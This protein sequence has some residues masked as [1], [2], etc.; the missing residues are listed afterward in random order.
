MHQPTL[1]IRKQIID[2]ICGG[3]IDL[4]NHIQKQFKISRQAV[5]RHLQTLEK[6]GF[7]TSKGK[8]K[9][10]T[11]QLG[12]IRQQTKVITPNKQIDEFEV[13]QQ[14]FEWVI[15]N[16]PA[17][18]QE[19]IDWGFTEILNNAI[20][21][22]Q[23]N[24]IT[25]NLEIDN[26]KVSLMVLDNGEGILDRIKRIK[27]FSNDQ[28]VILELSKGKLTTDNENHTGLGIFFSIKAFDFFSIYSNKHFYNLKNN[29]KI[30]FEKLGFS[31]IFKITDK[32]EASTI[33]SMVINLS[34]T[35]KIKTVFDKFAKAPEFE[36]N[37]TTVPLYLVNE[38]QKLVS[39]SQAK[40]VAN[41]LDEFRFVTFDF[42]SIKTI[43]QGFADELFRVYPHKNPQIKF[44]YINAKMEVEKMIKRVK[45]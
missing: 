14:N 4:N 41:R 34:S 2:A 5:N 37:I 20:D 40:Q 35:T 1:A 28:R 29:T 44:D 11:Y 10:K 38:K 21:H 3:V 9:N 39:R 33:V 6:E 31:K 24:K 42:K 32:K 19:I 45:V 12:V 7:L 23:A 30:D 8:T 18:I 17:N 22:S 27:G 36:F 13:Y 16:A 15:E 25:V 43:G 26:D